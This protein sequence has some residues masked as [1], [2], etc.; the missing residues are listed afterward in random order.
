MASLRFEWD[1]R[2]NASNVKKHGVSFEEAQ[3]AFSDDQG[4]VIEDPDHSASEDRFVLLG[5]S[6]TLRLLVV[7]HCV[8][9]DGDVIRLISARKAGVAERR[10]YSARW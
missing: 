8:R 1:E 6:S 5:M 4:L 9:D 10:A 3:T 2:K 7:C